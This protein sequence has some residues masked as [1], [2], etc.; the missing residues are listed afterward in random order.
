MQMILNQET[1]ERFIGKGLFEKIDHEIK[2]VNGVEIFGPLKAKDGIEYISLFAIITGICTFVAFIALLNGTSP[3]VAISIIISSVMLLLGR[4]IMKLDQYKEQI[5]KDDELPSI[6]GTLVVAVDSG[7]TFDKAVRYIVDN[8]VGLVRDLLYEACV[9]MDRGYTREVSLHRA[10]GKSLSRDFYLLVKRMLDEKNSAI[11]QKQILERM[12]D[13]IQFKKR[14][15]RRK[16]TAGIETKLF[17]PIFIFFF[18]PVV[19]LSFIPVLSAF[20]GIG[21]I[22]K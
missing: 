20:S 1:A 16:K 17:F 10:A 15:S 4:Y 18:L 12:Y 3:I 19:A 7:Y 2:V 22:F 6:L 8:K 13:R 21:S 9:D 11:K 5:M 14:M